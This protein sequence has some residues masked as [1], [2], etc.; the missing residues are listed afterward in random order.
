MCGGGVC[1]RV[2]WIGID[3]GGGVVRQAGTGMMGC[4]VM[5]FLRDENPQVC[6]A[7]DEDRAEMFSTAIMMD[8]CI[9]ALARSTAFSCIQTLSPGYYVARPCRTVPLTSA[10]KALL[11][12][13]YITASLRPRLTAP[14]TKDPKRHR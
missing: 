5:A 1:Y 3:G 14:Q 7:G 6:G 12:S 2:D 13:V 8:E 11:P 9:T 4:G 10:L